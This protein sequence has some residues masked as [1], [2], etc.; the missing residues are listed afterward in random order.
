MHQSELISNQATISMDQ[1]PATTNQTKVQMYTKTYNKTMTVSNVFGCLLNKNESCKCIWKEICY[2]SLPEILTDSLEVKALQ[3]NQPKKNTRVCVHKRHRSTKLVFNNKALVKLFTFSAVCRKIEKKQERRSSNV[4]ACKYPN[5]KLFQHSKRNLDVKPK[6]FQRYHKIWVEKALQN[7][8]RIKMLAVPTPYKNIIS[9]RYCIAN[10]LLVNKKKIR[11][12]Q[13]TSRKFVVVIWSGIRLLGV[14]S[15][16][17]NLEKAIMILQTE[18]PLNEAMEKKTYDVTDDS[19]NTVEYDPVAE[20]G[21]EHEDDDEDDDNDNDNEDENKS[22]E[23]NLTTNDSQDE[24]KSELE[25]ELDSKLQEK[26]ED[27]TKIKPLDKSKLERLRSAND[28]K[29]IFS[30][31]DNISPE[32]KKLFSDQQRYIES[33]MRNMN[34]TN[35]HNWWYAAFRQQKITIKGPCEWTDLM[36]RLVLDRKLKSHSDQFKISFDTPVFNFQLLKQWI[37]LDDVLGH[38]LLMHHIKKTQINRPAAVSQ[39]KGSLFSNKNSDSTK[40]NKTLSA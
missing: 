2:E 11:L 37:A 9:L 30:I 17:K 25:L 23:S 21:D 4:M 28:A 32:T 27:K 18:A 34:M 5:V 8:Q 7:D 20:H 19:D 24:A 13:E 33:V 31:R 1:P 6:P 40:K 29:A 12:R 39:K 15:S 38:R 10:H 16:K 3:V 36:D 35:E 26:T 22:D 14:C